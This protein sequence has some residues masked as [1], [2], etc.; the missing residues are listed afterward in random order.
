MNAPS[1]G[2][3]GDWIERVWGV[4]V[5][6]LSREYLPSTCEGHGDGLLR[7]QAR[8]SYKCHKMLHPLTDWIP[9]QWREEEKEPRRLTVKFALCAHNNVREATLAS[10]KTMKKPPNPPPKEMV[11][12]PIWTTWARY[13]AKV[14]FA[15]FWVFGA[16]VLGSWIGVSCF[17]FTVVGL[18]L[19]GVKGF[20]GSESRENALPMVVLR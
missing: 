11:Q 15:D 17:R 3:Q 8:N 14:R 5:Q 4:G 18:G 7:L 20:G 10:L 19:Q 6:N 2:E 16:R 9:P 13:H 12:A 1:S